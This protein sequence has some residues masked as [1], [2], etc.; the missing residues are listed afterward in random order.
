MVTWLGRLVM[1]LDSNFFKRK[2]ARG[3]IYVACLLHVNS[4]QIEVVPVDATSNTFGCML[5]CFVFCSGG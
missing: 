5:L 1:D 3:S 4:K 2:D